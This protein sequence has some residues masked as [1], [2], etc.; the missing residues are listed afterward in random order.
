MKTRAQSK[1]QPEEKDRRFSR[2]VILSAAVHIAVIAFI[3]IAVA[4][5]RSSRAQ[6]VA[7]TV[8]LVNPAALGTNIPPGGSKAASTPEH[9]LDFGEGC[10]RGRKM[11]TGGA[12]GQ[13]AAGCEEGR[14]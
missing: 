8:Q 11:S 12:R 10:R 14:A 5:S 9:L 2:M 4:R 7:Y 1:P 3:V 13:S 6:P